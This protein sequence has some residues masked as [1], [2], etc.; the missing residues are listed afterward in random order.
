VTN[1]IIKLEN[2]DKT[3]QTKAGAIT[4][5]SDINLSVAPGEIFGVIGKSG[6]G[7]STLIRC[8]NLLERP[9]RGSVQV[10]GQE[11]TTL[12]EKQLREVRHGIGMVFQHFNLLSTRTVYQNVALP[13]QLLHKSKSEID[14]AVMPLLELTG[15]K[16]RLHSYPSQLSGGQ[17]QRVAIARALAKTHY[18]VM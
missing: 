5:L 13:L 9:T 14:R 6:A 15:L 3:Y 17:K 8:V 10:D 16:E 18:I 7:K 4:A 2:V 1:Y 11:L 12:S